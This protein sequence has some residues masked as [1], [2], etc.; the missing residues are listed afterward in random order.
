MASGKAIVASKNTGMS[1]L[2]E[3]NVSGLLVDVERED[4][5]YFAMKELITNNDLR[6]NMSL[7]AREGI[8]AKFSEQ[9]VVQQ[10][11]QFYKSVELAG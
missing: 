9:N 8:I 6:Y 7:K 11:I 10:F 5:I 3:H 4:E 1:D 2:I